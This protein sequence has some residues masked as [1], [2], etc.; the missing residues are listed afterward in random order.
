VSGAKGK[1]GALNG[2]LDSGARL[3]GTLTFE[4]VFRIDG[5]FKGT[6]VS[7]EELVVGDAA[8]VEGEIR[9]GRLAVSGT[10]RGTIHARERVEVHAK[11]RIFADLH[12][13]S[14]IVEEGAIIQGKVETGPQ[15]LETK[16]AEATGKLA[17]GE[18][19][20]EREA[21]KTEK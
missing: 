12:T 10:I 19:K 14:L 8:T 4:D 3:E 6:I 15:A 1:S 13:P 5:Q 7:E 2:F 16:T 11:A 9:V 17:T 20:H 18:R 21:G